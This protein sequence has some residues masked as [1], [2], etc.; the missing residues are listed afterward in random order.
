MAIITIND[1]KYNIT[2]ERQLNTCWLF[3][4]NIKVDGIFSG[5]IGKT[6]RNSSC[7]VFSSRFDINTREKS[8]LKAKQIVINKIKE[9]L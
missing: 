2:F 1:K 8:F 9:K 4:Y 5:Y 3:D 6:N 7:I